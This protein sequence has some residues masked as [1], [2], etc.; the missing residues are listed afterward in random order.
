MTLDEIKAKKEKAIKLLEAHED[1]Y[2]V[3][4]AELTRIKGVEELRDA[5]TKREVLALKADVIH[6]EIKYLEELE[7]YRTPATEE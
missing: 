1:E 6:T 5:K 3:F 4:Y 7:T 2:R